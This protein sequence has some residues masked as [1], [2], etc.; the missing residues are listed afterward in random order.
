MASVPAHPE[1]VS[2]SVRGRRPSAW[3]G[4][5]AVFGRELEGWFEA[6]LA[7]L[8]I[9]AALF[10]STAWFM[11]EF[12]LAGALD[13]TPFFERL[14]LVFVLF[15]PALSILDV[16]MF[17]STESVRRLLREYDLS[18]TTPVPASHPS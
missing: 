14:P 8:A 15:V 3:G 12:F 9:A 6:P 2:S 17:N 4:V 16:L 5:R 18:P 13:M 11:N 7:W 1:S 10:A